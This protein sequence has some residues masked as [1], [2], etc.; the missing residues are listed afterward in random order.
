MMYTDTG[1]MIALASVLLFFMF[2]KT[3]G[4]SIS[5]IAWMINTVIWAMIVVQDA[6]YMLRGER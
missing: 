4:W 3:R 6:Y 1:L 2:Y 5:S